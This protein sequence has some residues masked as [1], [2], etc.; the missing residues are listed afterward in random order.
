[1]VTSIGLLH[2]E[3]E[4]SASKFGLRAGSDHD[5]DATQL[6]QVAYRLMHLGDVIRMVSFACLKLHPVMSYYKK[7]LMTL[8]DQDWDHR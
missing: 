1:M 5:H 6:G 4:R 7:L 8:N 2:D 3:L